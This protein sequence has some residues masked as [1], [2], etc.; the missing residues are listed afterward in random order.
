[1]SI[2][3]PLIPVAIP[4]LEH[5]KPSA[6][7]SLLRNMNLSLVGLVSSSAIQVHGREIELKARRGHYYRLRIKLL[8]SWR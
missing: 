5:H 2:P 1:M 3:K 4:W 7:L 6:L 8:K